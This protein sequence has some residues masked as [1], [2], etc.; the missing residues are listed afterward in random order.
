M[1]VSPETSGIV[2]RIFVRE[3]Q[4]IGKGATIAELDASVIRNN[5]AQVEKSLELATQLFEKQ[6]KLWDQN[7]GTEVQYLQAKNNK[8]SLEKNIATLNSQLSLSI[9]KSPI[10]G[11]VD[12]IYPKLGEMASPA[13]MFARVVS[14][15]QS[16][17][18]CDV[19]EAYIG[20][21]K[22]GDKVSIRFPNQGDES[23]EGKVAFTANYI[24]PSNRTFKVNVSP[25]RIP[26][27]FIPN[28][29]TVVQ[30][31]DFSQESAV[32]IP[33]SSV[34][35]DG[36]T[37]YVFVLV[38]EEGKA[39]VKKKK[40]VLGPSSEGSSLVMEGLSV[41]DELVVKGQTYVV[42]GERVLMGTK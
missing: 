10:S 42:D 9:I 18:S 8:E 23:V 2:K 19:S 35:D 3:G 17:V 16:Y 12:E 28:L 20:K 34:L 30:F 5:I 33:S 7:I 32:V 6:Q 11:T 25:N 37:K 24:N 4:R 21:I 36:Q 38:K 26:S 31:E 29:L 41:D 22:A 15:N 27:F 14:R 1:L 40:I 39:I 13:Q